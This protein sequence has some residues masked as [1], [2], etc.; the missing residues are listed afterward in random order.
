MSVLH[1]TRRAHAADA[2]RRRVSHRAP[3]LRPHRTDQISMRVQRAHKSRGEIFRPFRTPPNLR[4]VVGPR[5]ALQFCSSSCTGQAKK[6]V[7]EKKAGQEAAEKVPSSPHWMDAVSVALRATRAHALS[8]DIRL[9]RTVRCVGPLPCVCACACVRRGDGGD[10]VC[11][12]IAVVAG[13]ID[14]TARSPMWPG[15]QCAVGTHLCTHEPHVDGH[16]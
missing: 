12:R 10:R 11:V 6:A 9:I 5:R 7:A 16:L 15:G 3:A 8:G 2:R 4:G 14:S 1:P 13:S